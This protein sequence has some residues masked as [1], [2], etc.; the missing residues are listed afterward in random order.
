M[1]R[2]VKPGGYILYNEMMKDNLNEKQISHLLLHHFSAKIDRE[3]G[4]FHDETFNRLD[5]IKEI[6]K[7]SVLDLVDYWDMEVEEQT[8]T[9]EEVKAFASTVDRLLNQIQ[10][11][12]IKDKHRDEAEKIKQ[13]ILE[14][15]LQ[16]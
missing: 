2:L 3:V 8:P 6:Q 9:E 4:R 13:S 11:E 1:E 12:S 5:I 15:G 16:G 7:Y 10:D 14:N